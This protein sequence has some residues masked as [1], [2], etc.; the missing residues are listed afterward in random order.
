MCSR[1]C[2]AR[3]RGCSSVLGC[4]WS[5]RRGRFTGGFIVCLYMLTFRVVFGSC[6]PCILLL[7]LAFRCPH[8]Q[9]AQ[10]NSQTPL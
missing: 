5:A 8:M 6:F 4:A 10:G 7:C 3:M 9:F 1:E 2:S